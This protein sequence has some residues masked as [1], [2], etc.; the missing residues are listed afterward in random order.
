MDIASSRP[1][2]SNEI[3]R[4]VPSTPSNRVWGSDAIAA[5]LRELDIP[6][7]ALN[8]GASYR[9][10]HDSLVN[11]LGNTR[12][13]MLLCLHEESAVALA[14]GY[15]KV[16]GRP[17]AAF[18]HSNVG[19]MHATMAI[20]NAWCD[21][22]PV[23][24]LGA[25]GPMDSTRRRPWIEWIHTAR[26]QGA[27]IRNFT[28]WDDQ[29][30]SVGSAQEAILRAWMIAN[31]APQGPVYVNFDL[32]LQEDEITEVPA[33]PTVARYASPVA[34]EPSGPLVRQAAELLVG[35]R[36]PLILAGR[37][38]RDPEAWQR[39]VA[40]AEAIGAR[41]VT[42]R[43]SGATF[44]TDHPLH[45]GGTAPIVEADV[46][47]SLDWV[48]LAGTLRTALAGKPAT[49]K[50]IQ[51]SVDQYVHNGWSMDY[52]G[53]PPVDAYLLAE[54]DA[55]VP[56]L[57]A[58]VKALRPNAPPLPAPGSRPAP[59]PLSALEETSIIQVPHIA[60]ALRAVL[61]DAPTT[62]IRLPLSWADG[63]SEF[64]HPLDYLGT[65]GGGGIGSGPGMSVGAALAL[66]DSGSSRLPVA[67]LGDGDF[68]MGVTALWTAVRNNVP[69]LVIV[70]N[71]RS[72]F[73]DELHQERVAR[74]RG[75]PPENRW[76]GQAIRDP[77]IDLAT[78]ARG[79]GCTGIGPVED[80]SKLVPAL[81]EA[82]AAVRAGKV[83]VVDVRVA[84]G[85]S[86][87][88]TAAIMQRASG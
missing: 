19:L 1:A 82:V 39:R 65:D 63:L 70:A 67:V 32:A 62:M 23:L 72:F 22:A 59:P 31:T 35:A 3:D 14:H 29:P 21:R 74:Q 28:K 60:T 69:L 36:R 68:L 83:C 33:M 41:V 26:D 20:F 30:A 27:L 6:Y 45:V 81:R 55:A 9:G 37:G 52:Q 15:A 49:A 47:L 16:T 79:Q 34:P 2:E 43:K 5:M 76:I 48:D 51:V 18:V 4:P 88:A 50:I 10:I 8:P 53:L 17:M 56:R 84:P 25:T 46:I 85:Y 71:N 77:D 78:M 13:R 38:S 61:G 75:R 40:L 44:P 87:G 12:P 86:A 42:D 80:P 73:N 11:Y 57:L 58:A 64:R 66:R 7:I 54:P 24:V